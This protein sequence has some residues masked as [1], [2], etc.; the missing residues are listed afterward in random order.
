MSDGTVFLILLILLLYRKILRVLGPFLRSVLCPSVCEQTPSPILLH[1]FFGNVG[2]LTLTLPGT[3]R[4]VRTNRYG[5]TVRYVRMSEQFT[6][7]G[8]I[9]RHFFF[10]FCPRSGAQSFGADCV[11]RDRRGV[12]RKG[13]GGAGGRG[14]WGVGGDKNCSAHHSHRLT[15]N[16]IRVHPPFISYIVRY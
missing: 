11:R 16:D 10:C 2:S 8:S 13:A 1:F 14:A 3:Y 12:P 9:R 7:E 15:V 4:T 5:S 6:D